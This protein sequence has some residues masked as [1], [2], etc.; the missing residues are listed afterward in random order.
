MV[1]I[2]IGPV[3][4]RVVQVRVAAGDGDDDFDVAGIF[5]LL[6][7]FDHVGSEIGASGLGAEDLCRGHLTTDGCLERLD[8]ALIGAQEDDPIAVPTIV[9]TNARMLGDVDDLGR[10]GQRESGVRDVGGNV[11]GMADHH[12]QVGVVG[13]IGG[14]RWLVDRLD[15]TD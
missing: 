11:V 12:V 15:P 2:A 9:G 5:D 4:G 14:S 8:L 6:D 10:S 1:Q 7:L 3:A 13:D